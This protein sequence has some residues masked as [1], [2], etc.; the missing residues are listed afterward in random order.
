MGATFPDIPQGNVLP[1][2]HP[3]QPLGNQLVCDH[4]KTDS[5]RPKRIPSIHAAVGVKNHA[6][7]SEQQLH[8]HHAGFGLQWE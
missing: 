1:R 2:L 5:L 7:D 4:F 6:N 3:T 8:V